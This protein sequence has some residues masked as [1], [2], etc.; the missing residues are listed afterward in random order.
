MLIS[1]KYNTQCVILM[2]TKR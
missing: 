2:E 1:A